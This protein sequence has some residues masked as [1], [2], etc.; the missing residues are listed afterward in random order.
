MGHQIV[1]DAH[2]AEVL[3]ALRSDPPRFVVWDDDALLVDGLSDARVF[4][5]GLVRWID[6]HYEEEVRFDSVRILRPRDAGEPQL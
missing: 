3:E 5:S 6:D 1:T 2:R 4:G